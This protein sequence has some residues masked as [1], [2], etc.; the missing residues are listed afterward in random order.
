MPPLATLLNDD[1]IAAVLSFIR[2]SW[3]NQADPV[4]AYEVS[5]YRNRRAP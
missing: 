3:G 4:T 1:D 5:R 2:G